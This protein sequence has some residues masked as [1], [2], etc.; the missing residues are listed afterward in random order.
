MSIAPFTDAEPITDHVHHN[1]WSANLETP[2]HAFDR[3]LVVAQAIQAVEFT[4][5]DN[6]VNLVT[7]ANHGHPSTYL[8]QELDAI[9][10]DDIVTDYVE[11]CGCGGHVVRVSVP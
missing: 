3:E 5:P 11:R 10:G 1:S 4:A 9:F 6:H 2:E 8:Y 7:H